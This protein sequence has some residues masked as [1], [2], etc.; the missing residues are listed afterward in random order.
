MIPPIR[1]TH[2]APVEVYVD[3]ARTEIR[4]TEHYY[5]HFDDAKE[6]I[7]E[8]YLDQDKYIEALLDTEWANG[9]VTHIQKLEDRYSECVDGS[10][11]WELKDAEMMVRIIKTQL[12][13]Q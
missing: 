10:V 13:I 9:Y 4:M 8:G 11:F 5:L 3:I 6:Y 2:H 7:K 12:E 1:Y